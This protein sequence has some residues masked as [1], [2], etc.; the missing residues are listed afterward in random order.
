M[1]N[2][3]SMEQRQRLKDIRNLLGLSQAQFAAKIYYPLSSISA[4]EAGNQKLP[5]NLAYLLQDIIVS[6]NNNN[7]RI[8]TQEYPKR[9]DEFSLRAEWLFRGTGKPFDCGEI[10]EN[11]TRLNIKLFREN[12]SSTLSVGDNIIFFQIKDDLMADFFLKYDIIAFDT[13]KKNITSGGIYLIK[14]FDEYI[15]RKLFNIDIN[16]VNVTAINDKI[17]PTLTVKKNDIEIIGQYSYMIR[18]N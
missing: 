6:D 17:V 15:V 4:I 5:V 10:S 1:Q 13:T 11:F 9:E 2:G 3:Y 16:S 8:T 18:Q 12:K 7:V 14:M